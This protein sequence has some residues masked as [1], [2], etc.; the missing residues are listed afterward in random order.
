V[1]VDHYAIRTSF[2][3]TFLVVDEHKVHHCMEVVHIVGRLG[4]PNL[5]EVKFW[6]WNDS[7]HNA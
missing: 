2:G 1:F 3:G 7:P 6:K 4:V 5:A